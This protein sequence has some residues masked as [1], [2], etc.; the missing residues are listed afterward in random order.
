MQTLLHKTWM[1]VKYSP[2]EPKGEKVQRMLFLT[3]ISG[4]KEATTGFLFS[5]VYQRVFAP[6]SISALCLLFAVLVLPLFFCYSSCV[7][8]F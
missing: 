3:Y 1:Q 7:F 8:S 4:G 6:E 5:S 2:F